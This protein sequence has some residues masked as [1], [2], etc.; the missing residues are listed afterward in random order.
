MTWTTKSLL[1]T[2]GATALAAAALLPAGAASAAG[3]GGSAPASA[4]P[5]SASATVGIAAAAPAGTASA[6]A[7]AAPGAAAP[8]GTLVPGEAPSPAIGGPI[9]YTAYLPAGYDPAGETRYPSVYL[10]HGR[11]DSQSAWQ[12]VAPALD[13]M[14]A[15]GTI[16]PVVVI[17][18]DAPWSN[19]G[20]YYVD[21]QY[22]G[23]DPGTT[24]GAAV[25][26]GFT[27]DLVQYVDQNYRTV[28]DRSARVVGGYSMGGAGALRFALAHQDLFSSGL[29]L[30]P[31]VYVPSTPVDSSTRE[32]GAYGVG[33]SL[34]DEARYQALNYPAALAA[35]DPA[36]PVHLFIAVGDD[37]YVNPD[38]ADAI[39]DLDYEAATLYNKAKRVPGITAEFRTYDG[40]HDWGV[41]ERGFR[42][43]MADIAGYL[44]T[45]PPAPFDGV[46][47][48][49]AADDFAGGVLGRPDGSVVQAIDAGGDLPGHAGAGGTDI[50]VQSR[51]ADGSVS[52]TT[53]VATALNE[54]AYGVVD[55]GDGA[56]ITA[57]YQRRDHAGAQNDDLLA[58][59][60]DASGS[61]LWTAT[62]GDPGAADRAYGVASD[63]AGG[64]Y[65]AGYT[66][67]SAAGTPSA[68]DKDALVTHVGADG[69]LDWAT[70]FGSPGEDKAFSVSVAPDGTVYAGGTAAGAMPQATSVGGYDGWVAALAPTGELRWLQQFGSTS[71]DQ[72]S[73]VTATSDGV[74]AA[75]YTGGTLASSIPAG[76]TSA[77]G[78][79]LLVASFA[80]DGTPRS[81]AQAG[82]AGDDRA[83]ALVPV[84]DRMLVAGFTDGALG[85]PAG[86][87]DVIT[88]EVGADGVLDPATFA[89]FGSPQRDGADEYDEGNLFASAGVPATADTAGSV[90]VQG[91]T[92][93][94]VDG[95]T[96]AGGSDVFL[97]A[98]PVAALGGGTGPVDGGGDGSG[99]GSG[100]GAGGAGSGSAGS[101]SGSDGASG[102][103][104]ASGGSGGSGAL[105]LTGLDVTRAAALALLVLIGGT[106]AA[107]WSRRRRHAPAGH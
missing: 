40:G 46:Q 28:D 26:T 90:W 94:A 95:A 42:E 48:G 68:G 18:P 20:G 104:S 106:A 73:A 103:S 79:D 23:D 22:T 45:E 59:K 67:G 61:V 19:R 41:W 2:L 96:N 87:V 99:S 101:G 36:L 97:R 32:F 93:G 92:Y 3:P 64:A 84:G 7:A 75:G 85:T 13:E 21:S 54:R 78:V 74:V 16:P 72:V 86:G 71:G 12:Q 17:M 56:V 66:S 34:Y 29:V 105:G 50:L 89:Q 14:I 5:A 100:S 30:S 76:A 81:L 58:V 57:G 55:G 31:A 77:G 4:A 11:G 53:P 49:S 37:E 15:D 65:L 91:A 1:A 52:W 62:A 51:A 38:P 25:E 35:F 8:A 102:T 88:A 63:G 6:L 60:L 69:V 24:P 33:D 39:H 43:G 10:L 44:A 83:S 107:V 47:T 9:D 98:V 82:S 80:A 27:T 70:Q